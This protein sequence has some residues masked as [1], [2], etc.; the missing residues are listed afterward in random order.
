MGTAGII[1]R[2]GGL[3]PRRSA[4]TYVAAVGTA[5]E[6]GCGSP[7]PSRAGHVFR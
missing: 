7:G 5:R 1:A 6:A 2:N 3:V 4:W